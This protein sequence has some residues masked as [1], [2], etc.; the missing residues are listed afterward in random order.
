LIEA[1]PATAGIVF[2]ILAG[3][4]TFLYSKFFQTKGDTLTEQ[5]SVASN[6]GNIVGLN[7]GQAGDVSYIAHDADTTKLFV[8]SLNTQIARMQDELK[9]VNADKSKLHEQLGELRLRVAVPEN[10]IDDAIKTSADTQDRLTRLSNE[11]DAEKLK[12]AKDAAKVFDYSK[13]REIFESI[14]NR[15]ELAVAQTAS[16]EFGLG[17]IAE[18]EIRYHDAYAH[19]KRAYELGQGKEELYAYARLCWALGKYGEA[20]PMFKKLCEWEKQD[21]GVNDAA[22][23]RALN[24]LAQLYRAQG[25]HDAAEPLYLQ[26]MEIRRK[27]L[28]EDHPAYATS[29]NNLAELYRAQGRDDAAEPLFIQ[30]LEIRH[31][32]LGEDHPDYATSLNNLAELYDA[33]GRYDEAEPPYIQALE[34][35]RTALGED[36]PH[37]AASLNNL[38]GL[39]VEQGRLD[40]A[41]PLLQQALAIWEKALPADH[42]H[43]QSTRSRLARLYAER[44]DLRDGAEMS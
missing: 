27:A 35:T 9:S 42:A 23:A 11:V 12:Q 10:F 2:A 33:Q 39:C 5:K 31:K 40:E 4:V 14:R 28:G 20:E 38:G 7:I 15:N 43:T 30:A 25:R 16:A 41:A 1:H 6:S 24:N 34:I 13:A 29:L 22:Y 36:H 37:Y 32:A 26:A 18:N 17:E 21:F 44:P 8:E 3:V 19:F